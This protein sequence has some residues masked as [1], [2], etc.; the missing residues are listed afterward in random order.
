ML[1]QMPAPTATSTETLMIGFLG[2]RMWHV[3]TMHAPSS[4]Q[5]LRWQERSSSMAPRTPTAEGNNA[6]IVS[7]TEQIPFT[8]A[9]TRVQPSVL[10]PSP[11]SSLIQQMILRQT[12]SQHKR[13]GVRCEQTPSHAKLHLWFRK[14]IASAKRKLTK[15]FKELLLDLSHVRTLHSHGGC[16]SRTSARTRRKSLVTA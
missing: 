6:W 3:T 11:S 2:G 14:L 16:S 10:M 13:N 8:V 4:V 12:E 7:F 1:S 9:S 15:V 5:E